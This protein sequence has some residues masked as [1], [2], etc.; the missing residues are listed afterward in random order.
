MKQ[1]TFT[2]IVQHLFTSISILST[3]SNSHITTLCLN[4]HEA[5]PI[6]KSNFLIF[7]KMNSTRK[8][9]THELKT[10]NGV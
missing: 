8:C 6:N 3:E 7:N 4:V 1:S 2:I 10:C 9:A 5:N